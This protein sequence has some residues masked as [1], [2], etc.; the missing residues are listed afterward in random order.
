M[1]E[2]LVYVDLASASCIA[3][4]TG[5]TD[6]CVGVGLGGK[7]C[8]GVGCKRFVFVISVYVVCLE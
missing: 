6:D 4:S 7:L 8:D 5:D 1:P 3:V 2:M